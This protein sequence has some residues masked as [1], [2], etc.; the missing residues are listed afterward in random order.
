MLTTVNIQNI[1]LLSISIISFISCIHY[2]LYCANY[3]PPYSDFDVNNNCIV[4][5]NIF[6]KLTKVIIVY[7][8][9]DSFF[10]KEITSSIHHICVIVSFLYG[11]Y[12]DVSVYD[13]L[14]MIYPLIKT[15]ISSIFLV[16]KYY[17]PKNWFIYNINLFLFFASFTKFRIIDFYYDV[18]YN[19]TNYMNIVNNYSSDN[20][21]SSGIFILSFYGL[22]ILNIYWFLCINKILYKMISN[23]IK[24][25]MDIICHYLCSFI[26]WINIPISF[27]IYSRN[28]HEKNIYD[29][30]GVC[31]LSVY[32]Y[33]YHY[34]VYIRLYNKEIKEYDI[35][36]KDNIVL[37]LNDSISIH[38]RSLLII[39]T[40]Y[41]NFPYFWSIV[42]FSGY[43]HI[44][45]FYYSIINIFD[46]LSDVE[47]NKTTFSKIHNIYMGI[48]IAVDVVM[49]CFNSYKDVAVPFLS[50][51]IV[52]GLLF[53]VEPFY[54]LNHVAFHVLL[55][56]Q[57][58][59]VCLS[60]I[61]S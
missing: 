50:I 58:M 18:I 11:L 4:N 24:I 5:V 7:V 61:E 28:P 14:N 23:T 9:I 31:I 40:N 46:L 12:Y 25:D 49:I 48:P 2:E 38:L 15:E 13:R 19:N 34:D 42:G 60:S 6:D 39:I 52:M 3:P 1:S 57:N 27:F 45:F 59:Y 29:M 56:L 26:H 47:K 10:T 20:F 36:N 55:V 35:P 54:K 30:L 43:L 32:S 22:Y 16:C 33:V 53:I 41:Y 44:L 8:F 21:I 17:I 51:H 37:F